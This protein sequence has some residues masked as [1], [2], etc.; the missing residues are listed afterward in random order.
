[1][2][3]LFVERPPTAIA[4]AVPLVTCTSAIASNAI[5]GVVRVVPPPKR[6]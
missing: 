5:S 1:V 6:R 2:T 3:Y 4:C